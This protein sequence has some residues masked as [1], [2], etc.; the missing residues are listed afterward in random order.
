[1]QLFFFVETV[2]CPDFET[3]ASCFVYGV[4]FLRVIYE[5]S[6]SG[7]IRPLYIIGDVAVRIG[8]KRGRSFAYLHEIETAERACHTYGYSLIGVDKYI[9]EGRWQK[10]R[11][12]SRSVKVVHKVHGIFVYIPEYL[13]A[14]GSQLRFGISWS[15]VGHISGI[16]LSEISLRVNKWDEK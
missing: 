4:H 5:L 1:M 15:G 13:F 2:F 8:H 3:S 7:K 12:L 16:L 14:D 6:A 11:L 9:G 10:H